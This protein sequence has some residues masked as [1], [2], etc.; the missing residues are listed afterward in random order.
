MQ[1]YRGLKVQRFKGSKVQ[2]FKVLRFFLGIFGHEKAC[3]GTKGNERE[4]MGTNG[5]IRARMGTNGH[6]W[7]WFG[8]LS[9]G[10]LRR[11][12]EGTRGDPLGGRM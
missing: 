2:A 4:R 11:D 1:G 7:V 12:Y 9:T 3:L 6:E 5:N 8:Q 10:G